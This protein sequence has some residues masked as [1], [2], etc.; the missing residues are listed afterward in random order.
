MS[1]IKTPIPIKYK[2][3]AFNCNIKSLVIIILTFISAISNRVK[4]QRIQFID[5]TYQKTD[6][7]STENWHLL[8]PIK[9]SVPD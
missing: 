7:K 1:L 3:L 2:S 6:L 9:D 4:G 5:S 8:D